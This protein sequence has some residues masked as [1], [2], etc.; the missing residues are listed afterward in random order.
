MRDVIRSGTFKKIGSVLVARHGS[1]VS[2]DYF[3]GSESTLRDT[4]SATK[5]TYEY[6]D[7]DGIAIDKG[8]L[9]GV[10]AKIMSFFPDRQPMKNPDPRKEQITVEDFLTMSSLLECDDNNMFPRGHEERMYLIEDYVKFT[11][12]LPIK[13]IP[14]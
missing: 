14:S 7:R 13:A 11:L 4:R 2:E 6:S 10:D 8:F 3:E 1:L 9:S 5:S 12:D